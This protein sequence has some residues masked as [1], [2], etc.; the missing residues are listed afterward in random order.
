MKALAGAGGT[1]RGVD[2]DAGDAIDEA[3][4]SGTIRFAQALSADLGAVIAISGAIDI[5]A[6][7]DTVYVIRNGHPLMSKVTGTGCMLAALLGAYAAGNAHPGGA[8]APSRVS[9][10]A[11][12]VCLMGLSGE[13]AHAR[14]LAA[15]AGTGSFRMYL[16]DAISQMTAERLE[17]GARIE[18]RH[19]G[20]EA[21]ERA[22]GVLMGA[23]RSCG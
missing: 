23:G 15:D 13:I 5:V 11:A 12:A 14:M 2:A 9:D 4:L 18:C 1:T 21:E 20:A 7:P 19:Q 17:A 16:I 10:A 3:S 6:D 22:D 8:A